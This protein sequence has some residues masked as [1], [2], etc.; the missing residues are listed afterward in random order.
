VWQLTL[1]LTSRAGYFNYLEMVWECFDFD[2]ASRSH[3]YVHL[4]AR[5]EKKTGHNPMH[6]KL[7]WMLTEKM[8]LFTTKGQVEESDA[9]GSLCHPRCWS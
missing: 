6:L 7:H 4:A 3:C 8:L 5:C 9:F 2:S 1:K